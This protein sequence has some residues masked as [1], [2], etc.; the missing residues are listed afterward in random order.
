[1]LESARNYNYRYSS[2]VIIYG[3][4][5]V[6]YVSNILDSENEEF[7]AIKDI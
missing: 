3:I 4:T 7:L 5:I 1:M 6:F 2:I